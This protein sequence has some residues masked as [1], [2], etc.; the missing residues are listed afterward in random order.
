MTSALSDEWLPHRLTNEARTDACVCGTHSRVCARV[1]CR[2]VRKWKKIAHGTKKNRTSIDS[3]IPTVVTLHRFHCLTP[4][5]N[6]IMP[7][8][9]QCCCHSTCH[10]V[11]TIGAA[12]GTETPDMNAE[13]PHH[14]EEAP[15]GS[16]ICP[17]RKIF[18]QK[19]WFS[20]IFVV[21]L[22]CHWWFCCFLIEAHCELY[23][24][25]S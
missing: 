17:K 12:V 22:P 23:Q 10:D 14:L 2:R 18:R 25:T 6:F 21:P 20:Q 7:I 13:W 19:R 9:G 24:H 15:V 11:L 1:I 8:L 3:R 4:K 5:T 16:R